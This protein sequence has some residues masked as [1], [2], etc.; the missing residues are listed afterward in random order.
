MEVRVTSGTWEALRHRALPVR[1]AVFVDEQKVPPEEEVDAL[2]PGCTHFAALAPDG[3]TVGCARITPD[4]R[5]GRVAVLKAFRGQGVG[6]ALM[7]AALGHARSAGLR[8]VDLNAQVHARGFYEAF[9]FRAEGGIFDECGIAHV[10][11][12]RLLA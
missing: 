10:R 5:V 3:T 7:Q 1:L 12:T 4:G 2:D 11:M 8:R 6:R 9:G